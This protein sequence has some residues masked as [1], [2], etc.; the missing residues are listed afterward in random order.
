MALGDAYATTGDLAARLNDSELDEAALSALLDAASRHVEAYTRRQFNSEE[1]SSTRR[2][3]ALDRERLAVDDFYTTMDLAVEVDGTVWDSADYDPRPWDG[4]VYGRIEWP[5][6]DLFA[7]G[8]NWPTHNFRRA[9]IEV[10]ARWGWESVPEAIKQAT[11]DVAEIMSVGA[12][13]ASGGS[14][15]VSERIGDVSVGFG[16]PRVDLGH[17]DV[18]RALV[19]AAPYRRKVFGVG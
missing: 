18:P 19:K 17:K 7:V 15:V 2:Y 16:T 4:V 12:G 14:F 9:T 1:S 5:F 11:L 6:S 3:R 10:T 8:R 13:V